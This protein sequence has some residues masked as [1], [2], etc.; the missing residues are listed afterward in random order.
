MLFQY[1]YLDKSSVIL[2]LNRNEHAHDVPKQVS[3][4]FWHAVEE[5]G[6]F[7]WNLFEVLVQIVQVI[8][9]R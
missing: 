8:A 4:A 9:H 7:Q 5:N 2:L 1:R 3:S 6:L